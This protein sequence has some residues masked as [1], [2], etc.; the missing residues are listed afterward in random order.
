MALEDSDLINGYM[1]EM[2]G[3]TKRFLNHYSFPYYP[4]AD[5]PV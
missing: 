4:L 3:T 5:D 2:L 1:S